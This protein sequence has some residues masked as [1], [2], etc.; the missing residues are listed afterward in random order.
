MVCIKEQN[1]L[2][3]L[4][5]LLNTLPCKYVWLITYIGVLGMVRGGINSHVVKY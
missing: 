1:Q 2:V 3:V 4:V 5:Q